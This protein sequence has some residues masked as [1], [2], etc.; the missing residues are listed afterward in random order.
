MPTFD[1]NGRNKDGELIAGRRLAQ[2]ADTL[3]MQLIN[4]GI[5]PVKITLVNESPNYWHRFLN[6]L[7]SNAVSLDE[8]GLFARQMHTLT[9]TGVPITSA[10][11]QL[12]NNA[13]NQPIAQALF[14][15][16]EKLESGQD[17]AHAMEN[18]PKIF[19]PI[20][21]SMIRVGQS[22]GRLDEAFLRLNQYLEL[23]ASALK[24]VKSALRYPLIVFLAIITAVVLVNI[25]VIPSFA[26]VFSQINVQLPMMTV[27]L[28]T[29]SDWMVTYWVYIS[30]F[31]IIFMGI[32]YYY[33]HTPKGKKEWHKYQLRI[34]V[35]G[36]ILRRIIL[37]RFAQ[38]FA[39][40]I[41]SGISLLDGMTLVSKSVHNDYAE[42][43]ILQM[44]E[45][46]EHGKSLTQA[47]SSSD[48]FTTL[49]L[50]MLAVSEETGE[51]GQMLDEVANYYRREVEYDLKLLNDLIEPLLLI[52]L[53]FVVMMLALAVYLPIWDMIKMVH[54]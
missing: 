16:V 7:K 28:I 34:P 44:R 20:A 11:R 39:V 49:E 50:Q 41:H 24:R 17:L 42:E 1:F 54:A 43:K 9:K 22:S 25:L 6:S 23:E 30:G 21:V 47:A 33:V 35:I 2:T 8:L 14:G 52:A 48:L 37:L 18:Y 15:I 19:S 10:L 46:V 45:A 31:L 51:L 12:A 29:I 38:S 27:W 13:R 53:S 4:E 36:R 5:I 32:I 40:V 3:S 26:R